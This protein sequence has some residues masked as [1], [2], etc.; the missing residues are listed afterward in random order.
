[1]RIR[2]ALD[3]RSDYVAQEA[4]SD[5][6]FYDSTNKLLLAIHLTGENK[7]KLSI[8]YFSL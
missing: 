5:A 6:T 1:M 2:P 8:D 7:A 3:W 4:P